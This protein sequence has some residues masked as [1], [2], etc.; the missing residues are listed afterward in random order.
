MG[1]RH[2]VAEDLAQIVAIHNAAIASRQATVQLTP[3]T[4][5]DRRAWF[6]AHSPERYPLLVSEQGGEIAGWLSGQEF[7]P[8]RA[9]RG[10]IELSL[11]V[12]EH[13]RRRGVGRELLEEMIRRAPAR[14][15]HSLVG[16]VFAMNQPS[17]ALFR[18]AGFEQWGL[19]P[20][21][22]RVDGETRDLT[23]L[24]REVGPGRI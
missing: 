20:G 15:F 16:L 13:F 4:V 9:Y 3:V 10:T 17:I 8:R 23:I 7:L 11:Y 12:A 18:A 6:L 5:E 14:G 21:I 2:A 1:I 24:G 22:A 19:L